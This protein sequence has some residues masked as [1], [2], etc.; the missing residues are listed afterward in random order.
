MLASHL[1]ARLYATLD[2]L[3]TLQLD[4]TLELEDERKRQDALQKRVRGMENL[5]R[6][7]EKEKDELREVL[8]VVVR[9]GASSFNSYFCCL[10]GLRF[11]LSIATRS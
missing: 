2:A 8:E 4:H 11:G 7:T 6:D 9:K 10:L 1:Q 5:L 3:D